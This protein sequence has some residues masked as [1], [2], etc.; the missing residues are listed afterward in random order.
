M[1]SNPSSN[2]NTHCDKWG[3]HIHIPCIDA[4]EPTDQEGRIHGEASSQQA[5]KS[6]PE[7]PHLGPDKREQGIT[8]HAV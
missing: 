2:Q 5:R 7:F 6:Y 8:T 1:H 3:G 4:E